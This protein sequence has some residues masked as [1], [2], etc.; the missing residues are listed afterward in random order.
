MYSIADCQELT[1]RDMIGLTI[2][3]QVVGKSTALLASRRVRERPR[4]A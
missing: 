2:I 1:E 4:A 3:V